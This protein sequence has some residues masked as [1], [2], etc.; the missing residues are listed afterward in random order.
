MLEG[1]QALSGRDRGMAEN[2]SH[3]LNRLAQ[4]S[5]IVVWAHNAH[6]AVD[7]SWRN[8]GWRLRREFGDLYFPFALTFTRGAFQ[9]RRIADGDVE[10]ALPFGALEEFDA[11]EPRVGFWEKDLAQIRRGDYYLDLKSARAQDAAVLT[12]GLREKQSFGAGGGY[13]PIPENAPEGEL[14]FSKYR[15]AAYFDGV[16]HIENTTR[17]RPTPTG[18]RKAEDV[19]R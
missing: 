9:S 7:E 2:I 14:F 10:C 19:S 1:G 12:W 16:F 11:G 15:L 4:D 17:A 3:I 8:M 18:M 13:L 5:K 6:I